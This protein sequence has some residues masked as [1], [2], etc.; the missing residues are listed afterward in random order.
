MQNLIKESASNT[1]F[2]KTECDYTAFTSTSI[3]SRVAIE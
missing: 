2:L 3:L 1:Y